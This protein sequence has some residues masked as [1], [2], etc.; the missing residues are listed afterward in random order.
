MLHQMSTQELQLCDF[1]KTLPRVFKNRY[2]EQ[3]ENELLRSLFWSLA[4]GRQDYLRLRQCPAA[5]DATRSPSRTTSTIGS[6]GRRHQRAVLRLD[7]AQPDHRLSHCDGVVHAARQRRELVVID[8]HEQCTPTH[9]RTS[10][11]SVRRVPPQVK[12]ERA[13]KPRSNAASLCGHCRIGT[14]QRGGLAL[15]QAGDVRC[16]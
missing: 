10:I 15:R 6:G 3:A 2:T 14:V 16:I 13:I 9:A 5:P 8:T 4:G 7:D 12:R 1:L 11:S